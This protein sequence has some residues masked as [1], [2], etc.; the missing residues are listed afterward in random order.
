MLLKKMLLIFLIIASNIGCDKTSKYQVGDC[1]LDDSWIIKIVN[2]ESGIY[3]GQL[4][5]G[6]VG[7]QPIAQVD[8]DPTIK[9]VD[10]QGL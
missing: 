6:L 10:C 7:K 3:Y 9:K 8:N 5:N 4:S 2:V 1:L